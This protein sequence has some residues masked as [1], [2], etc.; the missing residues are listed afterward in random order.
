MQPIFPAVFHWEDDYFLVL[1][2][3]KENIFLQIA[4]LDFKG[5]SK[6]V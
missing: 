5:E 6:I 4:L 3:R 2:E 1:L